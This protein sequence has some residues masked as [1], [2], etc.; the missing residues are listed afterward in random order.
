M[1]NL[2]LVAAF[3]VLAVASNANATESLEAFLAAAKAGDASAEFSVGLK[4]YEGNTVTD[5]G[6]WVHAMSK[7]KG[8]PIAD[9]EK[10]WGDMDDSA[11]RQT[12]RE[13]RVEATKHALDKKNIRTA[14]KWFR[15]AAKHGDADGQYYLGVM[16]DRGQGV[17][18]NETEAT[19]W[20]LLSAQQGHADAQ[21]ML[22]DCYA[23]GRSVEVNTATA[24][25]WYQKAAAQGDALAQYL[26]EVLE[27]LVADP[28][29]GAF[30][31]AKQIEDRFE[32]KQHLAYE[33]IAGEPFTGITW[34]RKP[35]EGSPSL[36]F[37]VDGQ[38]H[39]PGSTWIGGPQ[40]HMKWRKRSERNYAAGKLEGPSSSWIYNSAQK[41]S[42][43][44]FV[45]GRQ[46]GLAVS[47]HENGSKE[48]EVNYVNGR[49]DGV[50]TFWYDSGKKQT[51]IDGEHRVDYHSNGQKASESNPINDPEVGAVE[52]NTQWLEN[53]QRVSEG[54]YWRKLRY[55]T[56]TEWYE[57]GEKKSEKHHFRDDQ[58]RVSIVEWYKNGQK[59]SEVLYLQYRP[60][61]MRDAQGRP[62]ENDPHGPMIEWHENG[63]KKSEANYVDGILQSRQITWSE[64][65]SEIVKD[66]SGLLVPKD[67]LLAY[68]Q[69]ES[70][71]DDSADFRSLDQVGTISYSDRSEGNRAIDYHQGA[72]Y[73]THDSGPFQLKAPFTISVWVKYDAVPQDWGANK[74][75]SNSHVGKMNGKK[76][77][78][79]YW[80]D[81]LPS[82]AKFQFKGAALYPRFY[83]N[84][85][86]GDADRNPF[87]A[88][89]TIRVGTWNHIA[90]EYD[91]ESRKFF[92]NGEPA[93]TQSAEAREDRTEIQYV[94]E[95]K[96]LVG[97]W[98]Q[99][100]EF[101]GEIDDILIY[102]RLLSDDEVKKI[103]QDTEH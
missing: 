50:H 14:L 23:F 58:G 49:R 40:S 95:S 103:Y 8:M 15:L 54:A 101:V 38:R 75:L 19:E 7:A 98:H 73:L 41:S 93:G 21:S 74:I 69:F 13:P 94:P 60:L 16:Y 66:T 79:G 90:V 28:P 86:E 67:G 17:K 99:Y 91:G 30:L 39:G 6:I 92:V 85:N 51:E 12:R 87:A 3:I 44:M 64:A 29:R 88:T 71:T 34:D 45:N 22:G 46:D 47:W 35:H 96:F 81:V 26:V 9:A 97:H 63:Q 42:E 102:K 43:K 11:Q 82:Q 36:T 5:R 61:P 32:N 1:R 70:N 78:S 53:G 10:L 83:A 62:F 4:Y 76:G 100:G 52:W 2:K 59:K 56:W 31:H 65:G 25:S 20:Y 57:T 37:Y 84:T 77:Y 33:K 27:P 24:L 48:S 80:L 89:S 55:G 18:K 68:F 72:G